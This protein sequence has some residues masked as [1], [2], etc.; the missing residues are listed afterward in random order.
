MLDYPRVRFMVLVANDVNFPIGSFGPLEDDV[1]AAA[2]SLA[3]K[4]MRFYISADSGTF[5]GL[6][7][8]VLVAYR[9]ASVQL[10]EPDLK[11]KYLARC[12]QR[13]GRIA[14]VIG[15]NDWRGVEYFMGSGLIAGETSVAYDEIFTA[16]LVACR[17]IGIGACLVRLGQRAIQ[18]YGQPII[19][20]GAAELNK[21]LG[22]DEY[23]SNLQLG[24]V[25]FDE[26]DR[27]IGFAPTKSPYDPRPMLYGHRD[28]LS[29]WVGGFFDRGSWLWTKNGWSKTA[30]VGRGRLGDV[31]VGVIAQTVVEPPGV[32]T[33]VS[34]YK[35]AQ[36]IC[37]LGREGLPLLIIA[38]WR[39]FSGGQ[40]DTFDVIFKFGIYIVV[41]LRT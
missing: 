9:I 33:P 14:D 19:L 1:S 20:T 23:T 28:Q 40:R 26:A 34:V 22:R 37:Y 11:F 27:D 35:T 29:A 4:L 16:T 38:N 6:T 31:P 30:V 32:W 18:C 41:M 39:G 12:Q 21:V 13:A 24:G 15:I 8:E 17:S 2:S 7:N 3:C 25:Q 5:M 10:C 36:A